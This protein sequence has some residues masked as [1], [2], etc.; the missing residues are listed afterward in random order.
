MQKKQ[1]PASPGYEGTKS[2]SLPGACKKDS[3]RRRC[4]FT[5]LLATGWATESYT[6]K[7]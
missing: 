3:S 2:Y 6:R 5:S 4:N 7:Q 1:S